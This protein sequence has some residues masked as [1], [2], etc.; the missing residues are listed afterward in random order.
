SMAQLEL[1]EAWHSS[2]PGLPP[3]DVLLEIG[4][5]GGRT[6]CRTHEAAMALAHRVH[7]GS[8]TRLVGIECYEGLGATGESGHDTEYAQSL[9]QRVRAVAIECDANH[10]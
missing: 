2:Q 8:A 3:F 4:V 5:A 9:M 6:G 1:V 7:D 10:L